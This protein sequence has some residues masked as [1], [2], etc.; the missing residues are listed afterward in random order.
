MDAGRAFTYVFEDRD[1]VSKIAIMVIMMFA[2][3]FL[4]PVI[5][6]GFAPLCMLLGYMAE[7]VRNVRDEQSM[8]LPKWDDYG[9]LFNTGFGVLIGFIIYNTPMFIMGFCLTSAGGVISDDLIS[10]FFT[11]IAL[12]C[13]VPIMLI[14]S[15]IFY[16][17]LGIGMIRYLDTGRINAFFD[18]GGLFGTMT[19]MGAWTVQWLL[20]AIGVNLL[21][22]FV[23]LIPCIGQII[24]AAMVIPV[25]GHLLGQYAHAIDQHGNPD[26]GKRKVVRG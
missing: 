23:G 21:F 25:Q 1:W 8:I 26:K 12:C 18:L 9:K 19:S 14:Y 20:Y 11:I 16:P 5:F 10:G 3:I 2:S 24:Y 13:L 17:M 4:M 22:L 7:I 6:L 15:V